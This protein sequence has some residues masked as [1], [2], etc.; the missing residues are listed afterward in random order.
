MRQPNKLHK[1][2]DTGAWSPEYMTIICRKNIPFECTAAWSS[3]FRKRC[4]VKRYCVQSRLLTMVLFEV[5]I[6][7]LMIRSDR[8]ACHVSDALPR[9]RL[10]CLDVP[11]NGPDSPLA[12]V[13]QC[14]DQF[15]FIICRL[16]FL[17]SAPAEPFPRP[18]HNP[19]RARSGGLS[20]PARFRAA[21]RLG[22]DRPSTGL[23]LGMAGS[24]SIPVQTAA[25]TPCGRATSIAAA[26]MKA[27][28]TRTG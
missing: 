24:F 15:V 9:L 28:T 5:G 2:V 26:S 1:I 22:L 8:W 27:S 21:A 25:Q 20:R 18:G 4:C 3:L 17:C 13:L 7:R 12:P 11:R 16:P 14:F 6:C 19:P 10:E 23:R